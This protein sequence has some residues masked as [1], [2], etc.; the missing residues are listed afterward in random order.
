MVK[1]VYARW[2]LKMSHFGQKKQLV[3]VAA[4][5]QHRIVWETNTFLE[6]IV[7]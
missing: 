2:V 6:R 4:E 5:Y 3:A 7:T 1:K